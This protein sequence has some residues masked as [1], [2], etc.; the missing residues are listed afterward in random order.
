MRRLAV[1][2]AV[3]VFAVACGG[4]GDDNGSAEPGS[5]APPTP[6]QAVQS[7]E[8]KLPDIFPADFPLPDDHEV[9]FSQTT[10][11]STIIYF[12]SPQSV[13]ELSAFYKERLPKANWVIQSCQP[14]ESP[15]PLLVVTVAKAE[16]FAIVS[17]G[18][19]PGQQQAFEGE[20]KFFVAFMQSGSPVPQGSPQPCP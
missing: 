15:A 18:T 12:D 4:G 9:V 1:L 6:P 17:I 11:Q 3:A 8:N 19:I 7:T 2:A 20:F 13:A 5:T 10:D 14:V 16:S